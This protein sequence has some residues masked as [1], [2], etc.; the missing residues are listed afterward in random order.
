LGTSKEER[1]RQ[2]N[3]IHLK[4]MNERKKAKRKQELALENWCALARSGFP[5]IMLGFSSQ[6]Q[7]KRTS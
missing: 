1:K 2:E 4:K 3:A 6:L 5:A 7:R